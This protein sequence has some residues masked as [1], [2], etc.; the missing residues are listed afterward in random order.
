MYEYP[1]STTM[2]VHSGRISAVH[3]VR[4]RQLWYKVLPVVLLGIVLRWPW[5]CVGFVFLAFV[6]SMGRDLFSLQG[7]SFWVAFVE[8]LCLFTCACILWPLLTV[9]MTSGISLT[10]LASRT[11]V[12]GSRGKKLVR[13]RSHT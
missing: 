2:T 10:V 4:W 1:H 6:L 5:P 3:G 8:C 11:P 12:P 9:F 13:T 7:S